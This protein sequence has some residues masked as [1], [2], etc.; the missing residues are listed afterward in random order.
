MNNQSNYFGETDL[1]SNVNSYFVGLYSALLTVIV[2]VITFILAMFAVPISGVFCP[3]NCI[4]YPY[5]ETASQF[6]NDYLWMFPVILLIIFYM[7]LM[8]SINSISSN[9]KKIYSQIGLMFAIV[10]GVILLSNY[11]IQIFVVPISIINGETQ[12]IAILTQ[13]N[14]HGIFLVLENLGYLVMSISFLFMA[15]I[16]DRR[17]R[18][19][20]AIW[21]VFIIGFI[22]TIVSFVLI[23]FIY[24]LEQKD[25]FEVAV[26]SID[27]LVLIVNG[28]LLSMFFNKKIKIVKE[29]ELLL[30]EFD[31]K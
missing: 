26:I 4:E 7:I 18:L 10:S 3:Q 29:Q 30:E 19:R 17:D 20:T 8:V 27:W 9:K 25:R 5:L 28:I 2:T 23:T 24:G 15:L 13:Y 11:F 21:W 22:L 14:P 1:S 16:F 12:G 6:P 31:D